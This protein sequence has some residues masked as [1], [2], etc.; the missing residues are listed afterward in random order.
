MRPCTPD[1]LP[2]IGRTRAAANLTLATGHATVGVTLAPITGL[3]VAQAL[4]GEA[5]SVDS[6]L[7]SPDRFG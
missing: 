6:P 2:A 5:P 1:G 3:L 7:L 4:S